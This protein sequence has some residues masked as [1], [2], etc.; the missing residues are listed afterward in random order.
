MLLR[1]KRV[2]LEVETK[3]SAALSLPSFG[4]FRFMVLDL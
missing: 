1:S 4:N 2:R 3:F